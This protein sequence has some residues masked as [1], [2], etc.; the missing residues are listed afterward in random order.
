MF[1]CLVMPCVC[2]LLGK[3]DVGSRISIPS[4]VLTPTDP[5]RGVAVLVV[6]SLQKCTGFRV[7]LYSGDIQVDELL[8]YPNCFF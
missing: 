5:T 4:E 3:L 1:G 7:F 8:L 6:E 2:F